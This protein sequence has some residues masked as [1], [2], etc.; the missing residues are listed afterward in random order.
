[1]VGGGWSRGLERCCLGPQEPCLAGPREAELTALF[2]P[3]P[4]RVSADSLHVGNVLAALDHMCALA[5][6][7]VAQFL[8]TSHSQEQTNLL[9]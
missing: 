6:D 1:M 4:P 2:S 7:E 9:L 3:P 8:G 5:G